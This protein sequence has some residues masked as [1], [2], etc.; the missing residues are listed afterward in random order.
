MTK[1]WAG[2]A[3]LCLSALSALSAHG[4]PAIQPFEPD[5]MARIIASQKGRPFVLVVWS[6]DCTYCQASLKTLAEEK[7]KRKDLKVV[8]LSTDSATDVHAAAQ[9]KRKLASVGMSADAW[10]YGDAPPEQ[11]RYAIDPKWHGEKPRSYW[12]S[13]RGESVAYSGVIT[14]AT[15][16]KLTAR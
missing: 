15:V 7:R 11:L 5:G 16:A 14:P 10:A 9:M 13:A 1:K 6:L 2:T 4:A 3:V 8:T 12:F